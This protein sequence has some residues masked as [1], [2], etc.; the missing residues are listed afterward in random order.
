MAL[1][2]TVPAAVEGLEGR[3]HHVAHRREGDG[4]VER[5]R[6]PLL[7]VPRPHGA[8]LA[9]AAALGLRAGCDIDL[10]IPVTGHLD[11]EQRRGAEAVEPEAT[12]WPD[13]RRS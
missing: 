6:R 1:I 2:A 11:G 4:G 3:D 9:R 12:T 7:V 5:G 8:E 13:A 10:A